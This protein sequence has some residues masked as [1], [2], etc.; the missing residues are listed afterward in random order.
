MKQKLYICVELIGKRNF[1]LFNKKDKYFQMEKVYTYQNSTSVNP[2]GY[3]GAPAADDSSVG[4]T[5]M[6][7]LKV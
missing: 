4:G 3:M 1:L 6:H 2:M 7:K 5:G